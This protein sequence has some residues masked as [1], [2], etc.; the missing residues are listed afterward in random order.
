M[1]GEFQTIM[2][3]DDGGAT[4]KKQYGGKDGRLF[5]IAFRD[6]KRGIAV[7][8]S[9]LVLVTCDGGVSWKQTAT[10]RMTRSSR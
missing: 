10:P 5:G 7:G 6:A 2:H 4:W 9:G 3:T 1:A 8:T